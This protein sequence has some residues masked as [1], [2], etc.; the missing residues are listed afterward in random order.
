MVFGAASGCVGPAPRRSSSVVFGAA[1]GCL[2]GFESDALGSASVVVVAAALVGWFLLFKQ[3]KPTSETPSP[4]P[5]PE[6][7]QETQ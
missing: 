6:K 5:V 1:S 7:N 3:P 2:G 4:V